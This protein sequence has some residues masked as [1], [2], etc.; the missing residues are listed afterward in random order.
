LLI[1]TLTWWP[2]YSMVMVATTFS[3]Y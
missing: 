3:Q 1:S 2:L